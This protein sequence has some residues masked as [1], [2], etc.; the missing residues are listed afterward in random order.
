[1]E[2]ILEKTIDFFYGEYKH[3]LLG[4]KQKIKIYIYT[5]RIDGIGYTYYN[6]KLSNIQWIFLFPSIK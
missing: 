4:K 6:Y 3:G 5:N 1:M 2:D